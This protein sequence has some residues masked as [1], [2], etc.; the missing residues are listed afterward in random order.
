MTIHRSLSVCAA[1]VLLA[2]ALPASATVLLNTGTPDGSRPGLA[3]DSTDFL[4]LQFTA[5]QA[6][7]IAGVSV[8]LTGGSVGDHFA[9]VLYKDA[10]GLPGD[11][12][13]SATVSFAADGWNGASALG[14]QLPTAGRYWLGIEGLALDNGFGV[15]VPQG[16]FVATSGGV[17]MPGAT[18]FNSGSGYGLATGGLQFGA[19]VTNEAPEPV[20]LALVLAALGGMGIAAR[21]NRHLPG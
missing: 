20:S 13:A 8:Y 6:W 14:W 19:M 5:P 10:P 11:L 3:V 21:R 9:L 15:L 7:T 16:N 18:A 12:L 1:A 4:A 17:T 2:A